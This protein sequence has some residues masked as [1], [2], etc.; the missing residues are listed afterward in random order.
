M[1]SKEK[2]NTGFVEVDQHPSDSVDVWFDDGNLIVRTDEKSFRIYCGIL[3]CASSVFRDIIALA[4]KNSDES[5]EGCPAVRVSDAAA[6]MSFFLMSLHDPEY[7]YHDHDCLLPFSRRRYYPGS[8]FR[9]LPRQHLL[10]QLVSLNSASS[11]TYP[12]YDD[13]L[14]TTLLSCTQLRWQIGMLHP[15]GSHQIYSTTSQP[16]S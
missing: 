12:S 3:V 14:S 15:S 1:H 7:V 13:A 11:T 2:N 8:S 10:L 4:K 9:L 16:Y 5:I 6:D